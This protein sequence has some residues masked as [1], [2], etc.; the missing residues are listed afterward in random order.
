MIFSTSAVAV[1]CC[2][3]CAQFVQQPRV[4]DGDH[5]LGGEV[6]HQLDLL[7]GEGPDLLAVDDDGADQFV[8]LEHRDT[9]NRCAPRHA[10]PMVLDL[11]PPT[12]GRMR[13]HFRSRDTA[14]QAA[15]VLER[16]ELSLEFDQ[17]RR[18]THA[19]NA[20]EQFA[21]VSE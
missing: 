21:V 17:R 2:R 14:E 1:C 12:V 3:D 9:D 5:G 4:L 8:V 15:S 13:N 10:W 16:A 19:S 11:G 20:V 7:V 18:R 6:L